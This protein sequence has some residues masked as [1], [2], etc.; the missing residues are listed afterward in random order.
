MDTTDAI[1]D[2]RRGLEVQ[3]GPE[4]VIT[5]LTDAAEILRWWTS[6]TA[7]TCEGDEVTLSTPREDEPLT[8]VVERPAP[9]VVSWRVTACGFLPDWVGTRPT[10]VVRAAAGRT[11]LEL[12]HVGLSP[13]LECFEQCRGGWDHFLPSLQRYVETGTG[14][15]DRPRSA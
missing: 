10:F 4:A 13:A 14:L 12:H 7:A 9:D 2:Y 5:A 8:F 1:T 11:A 15:P 6:F 3:A